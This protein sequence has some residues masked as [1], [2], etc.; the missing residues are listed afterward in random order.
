MLTVV[1][2]VAL[3][4]PVLLIVVTLLLRV[5]RL[6]LTVVTFVLTE[7]SKL[8]IVVILVAFVVTKLLT[9]RT[10]PVLGIAVSSDPSPINLL[11]IDPDEI[12]EKNPKLVDIVKAEMLEADK[13]PVLRKFVLRMG[14]KLVNPA[15]GRPV[16]CE[17]SPTKRPNTAPDEIEETNNCCVESI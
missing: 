9:A 6:V 8:L 14:G 12:V 3:V 10:A 1:I 17:P 13:N 16:N 5:L 15:A 7:L 4:A 2:F 11:Y